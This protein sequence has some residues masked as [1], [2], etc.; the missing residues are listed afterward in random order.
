MG[1][2]WPTDCC[3]NSSTVDISQWKGQGSNSCS[4][5]SMRLNGLHGPNLGLESQGSPETLASDLQS[6]LESQGSKF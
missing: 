5:Q 4:V 2:E 6:T 3:L 1:L